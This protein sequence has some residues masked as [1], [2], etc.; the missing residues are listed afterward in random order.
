MKQIEQIGGIS[1]IGATPPDVAYRPTERIGE[2]KEPGTGFAPTGGALGALLVFLLFPPDVPAGLFFLEAVLSRGDHLG[3][4]RQC[5]ALEALLALEGGAFARCVPI[6]FGFRPGTET[7]Q[8][9][10]PVQA[11]RHWKGCG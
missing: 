3:E 1:R 5:L 7:H 4:E 9:P 10:S 8:A 2:R 6:G 11:E